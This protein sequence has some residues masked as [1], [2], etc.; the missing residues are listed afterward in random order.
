LDMKNFKEEG[1]SYKNGMIIP[2]HIWRFNFQSLRPLFKKHY[3]APLVK[4]TLGELYQFIEV[5]SSVWTASLEDQ[6][7]Q[8]SCSQMTW[9]TGGWVKLNRLIVT[10]CG[11]VWKSLVFEQARIDDAMAQAQQYHM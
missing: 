2:M 4:E 7:Q 8:L 3:L 6:L 11:N 9:K 10:T 5:L 1:K